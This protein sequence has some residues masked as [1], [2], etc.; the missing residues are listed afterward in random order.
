MPRLALME[1]SIGSRTTVTAP[2]S[3]RSPVAELLRDQCE[4]DSRRVEQRYD[5]TLGC[6]V[7]GR[8]VVSTLT[9]AHHDLP[10]VARRQLG[11]H[12]LYLGGRRTTELQPVL[13]SG[14]KSKPEGSLG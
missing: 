11:E 10:L 2:F 5:G 14:W 9:A 6:R 4:V 8:R 7:D 1:P 3:A 13:H 12:R